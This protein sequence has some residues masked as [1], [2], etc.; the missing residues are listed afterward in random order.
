VS[1]TEV[2]S[3]ATVYVPSDAD[4][5][6]WCVEQS[7]RATYSDSQPPLLRTAAAIFDWVKTGKAP[8]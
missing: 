4:L 5:R 3:V 2:N 8:E 6:R 7:V 1:D